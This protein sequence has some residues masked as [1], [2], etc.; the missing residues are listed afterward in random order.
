MGEIFLECL[1]PRWH[2]ALGDKYGN[3]LFKN[4][5]YGDVDTY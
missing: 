4:I 2:I 1:H 3:F 5:L